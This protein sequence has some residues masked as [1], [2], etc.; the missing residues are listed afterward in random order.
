MCNASS[1]VLWAAKENSTF[2][3]RSNRAVLSN[4]GMGREESSKKNRHCP[5]FREEPLSAAMSKKVAE[6][7]ASLPPCPAG[8]LTCLEAA[9]N[10]TGRAGFIFDTV[11]RWPYTQDYSTLLSLTSYDGAIYFHWHKQRRRASLIHSAA[12]GHCERQFYMCTSYSHNTACTLRTS[13]LRRKPFKR[14]LWLLKINWSIYSQNLQP[15]IPIIPVLLQSKTLFWLPSWL[16]TP[17][18]LIFPQQSAL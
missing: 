18:S 14:D 15:W 7:T 3:D 17:H 8:S 16:S 4:W 12:A 6:V 5:Q 9:S 1:P 13:C 11:G 2:P 10:T